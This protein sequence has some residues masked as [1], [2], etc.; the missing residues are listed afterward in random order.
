MANGSYYTQTGPV[1]RLFLYRNIGTADAPAYELAD[2]DYLSFSQYGDQA[3]A[4]IPTVGDLDADGDLDLIVGVNNGFSDG[5]LAYLENTAGAGNAATFATPIFDWQGIDVGQRAAPELVD[6]DRDGDLDL[7]IGERTGQVNYFP[8]QGTAADPEFLPL[9]DPVNNQFLG[10]IDVTAPGSTSGRSVPR[11]LQFED[12]TLLFVGN[13][14]GV[15]RQYEVDETLLA[16]GAFEVLDETYGNI[17]VGE[18]AAPAFA[19]IDDDG[20][21]ELLVGN[22][23]GGFSGF[24][25]QLTTNGEPVGTTALPP[26]DG[27]RVYPNPAA[28]ALTVEWGDDATAQLILS[29]ALGRT[30]QNLTDQRTGC[31]LD[32]GALPPGLYTLRIRQAG[33]VSTVKVVVE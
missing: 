4:F 30:L 24:R 6:L 18:E 17:Q 10:A 22:I 26:V 23:R 7:L 8:N 21:F 25:T 33:A 29:D 13:R 14:A 12:R 32:V 11:A 15:V 20:I 5:A 1:G 9:N 19:D 31:P 16:G 27:L 28:E 2:S 3:S